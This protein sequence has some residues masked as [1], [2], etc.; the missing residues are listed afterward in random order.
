[1]HGSLPEDRMEEL[2]DAA[3]E[4]DAICDVEDDL[5]VVAGHLPEED[6]LNDA[7]KNLKELSANMRGANKE[8]LLAIIK[9]VESELDEQARAIEFAQEAINKALF[10]LP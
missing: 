9:V 8:K 7:V 1:M 5:N 4:L 2:L 10:K 6:F 3:E